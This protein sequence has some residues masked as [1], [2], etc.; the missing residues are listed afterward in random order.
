M[1]FVQ[2]KKTLDYLADIWRSNNTDS[3]KQ[4]TH[5]SFYGGEPLMNMKLIKQT[6]KY[7]EQIDISR[8]FR[9]SMTTNA[10]LLDK[11]MEYL[12]TKE[13]DLLISLDGDE[14]GHSYRVKKDGANSFNHVFTN[15]KL[16]RSKYPDYFSKHVSFNSVLHNR[17]SVEGTYKFIE[18]EFDKQTT[19]SELNNSGIRPE[20]IN[21]FNMTY[22]NATDSIMSSENYK[23]LS[24]ELFLTEPNTSDLLNYLHKYSGNVFKNYNS[25]LIN[26]TVVETIPTGTC[27]PFWKKMFVTVT[28]KI[29]Q[30][31]RINHEF[32]LG[33]VTEIGVD[34]NS[35]K[36]ASDFNGYLDKLQQQCDKCHRNNGC[37]QCLF[38]I[39]NISGD[40]P[41]C[42]G[43]M[44]EE[45]FKQYS[46]HC[47]NHLKNN[48]KLYK[49]LMEE[50]VMN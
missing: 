29:L 2:V 44:N 50:V 43:F 34:L 3:A 32:A 31:E 4:K 16:L 46:S 24:K 25:L 39:D 10:M 30:C 45:K 7:V 18:H 21:E 13:V 27:V 15:I 12:V 49:Q 48:P 33:S 11:F 19:I 8:E 38:Y 6:I 17:N 41:K 14:R 9:F 42:Q 23:Q 5:I 22:Q 47:L 37:M 35:D 36:I 26:K 28:G 1:K 20:K 40:N